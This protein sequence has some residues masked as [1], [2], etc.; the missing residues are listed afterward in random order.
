MREV[1]AL[2]FETRRKETFASWIETNTVRGHCFVNQSK[3][4]R[5]SLL[6]SKLACKMPLALWAL[7]W[8]EVITLCRKECRR[9]L[10]CAS[11]RRPMLKMDS[12]QTWRWI[13]IK[14][15]GSYFSNRSLS[16]QNRHACIKC[17]IETGM[18]ET[19]CPIETCPIEQK[20]RHQMSNRSRHADSHL[21]NRSKRNRSKLV[22]P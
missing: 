15:G 12:K 22:V 21:S 20:C 6:Q 8:R 13:R 9:P 19:I 3:H 14:H 2:W 1:P 11:C 18:Q 16:D 10:P 5:G 7:A 4:V 17:S